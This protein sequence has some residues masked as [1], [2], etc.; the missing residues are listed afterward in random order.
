MAL[1]SLDSLHFNY[2]NFYFALSTLVPIPW[3]GLTH[4]SF[5]TCTIHLIRFD[6]RPSL[7]LRHSFRSMCHIA[8]S[9]LVSFIW[10]D[11]VWCSF[12]SCSIHLNRLS[13][14]LVL[15]LCH[16]FHEFWHVSLSK[17]V[18]FILYDFLYCSF[19]SCSIHLSRLSYFF[20]ISYWICLLSFLSFQINLRHLH[21]LFWFCPTFSFYSLPPSSFV[22]HICAT[23]KPLKVK[24]IFPLCSKLKYNLW[25][26]ACNKTTY[27]P[28]KN[29]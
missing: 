29:G 7:H 26:S 8:F 11:S 21:E 22:T 19:Y 3:F 2:A 23:R 12:Y 17:P 25:F 20:T 9:P 10:F 18:P 13:F 24:T 28:V 5:R 15:H 27:Q 4:R 6:L 14:L 1:R 16:S